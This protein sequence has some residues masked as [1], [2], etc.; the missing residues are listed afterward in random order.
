M[1]VPYVGQLAQQLRDPTVFYLVI[2]I[3]A[4][5]LIANELR[6]IFRELGRKEARA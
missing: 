5:L 4:V 3:P 6:N 2:G 1:Q